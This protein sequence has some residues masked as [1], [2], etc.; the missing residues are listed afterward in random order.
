[1]SKK[2]DQVFPTSLSEIAFILVFLLMLLLGYLILKEQKEKEEAQRQLA[3]VGQVQSA[4]AATQAMQQANTELTQ[5]LASNGYA[6]PAEVITQLV[7]A[8]QVRAERDQLR[9]QLK[10]LNDKLT[11]LEEIR[12]KIAKISS[13]QTDKVAREEVESALHLQQEIRKLTQDQ[14]ADKPKEP[15]SQVAQAAKTPVNDKQVM[16]RVKQAIAATNKLRELIKE[17]LER[18]INPGEEQG[19]IK[20]IVTA[21]KGYQDLSKNK[22]NPEAVKKE[23][24]DAKGQ[25]AY[26]SRQ[27]NAKGGLDHAPCWADEN[28]KIEYLFTVETRPEGFVISKGWLLHREQDT[29]ALPGIE[30]ALTSGIQPKASFSANMLPILNWSKKQNPECR[31]FVY[32][33]TTISDADTRDSAR[34]VVEGFFYKLEIKK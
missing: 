2:N 1:M 33:F 31:H 24:A 26:L 15:A 32:L 7:E 20:E 19:A 12:D 3:M 22:E 8:S 6:K 28:G 23:L 5:T 16:D 13:A 27:I 10:E 29:K 34:K 17:K 21:A 14:T 25:L 18:D 30:Q 9:Q 11:A 4:E